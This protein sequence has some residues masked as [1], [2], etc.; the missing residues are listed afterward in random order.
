MLEGQVAILSSQFLSIEESLSVLDSLKSSNL[1]RA[2]QYSYIL[3][4]NKELPGF[5]CKNNIDSSLIDKSELLKVL[6]NDK[7]MQ[8]VNTD[9]NNHFHFNGNFHNSLCL[10]EELEKLPEAYDELVK[11]EKDLILS[12]FEQVF[13][14]KSFTGRSGTFYGYEGLGSIYWHMV[15]KLL[16]S[17]FEVTRDSIEQNNDS[18]ITGRLFDHYFEINEGIGTCLLYTSDAADE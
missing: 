13:D 16:L 8:I 6:L 3:Y 12:I 1:F 2:D 17:V 14:H 11:K 4:P 10:R 18:K 15:S 9:A 5:L 7:N